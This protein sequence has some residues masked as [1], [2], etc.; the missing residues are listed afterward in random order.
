MPL[1]GRLPEV[2]MLPT[3]TL[4]ELFKM[5]G[6]DGIDYR[7]SV[8]TTGHNVAL[9]DLDAATVVEC[10]LSWISGVSFQFHEM[11]CPVRYE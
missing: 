4:A 6:Y 1:L 11:G 7:S 10:H 8:S 2:T 3:Q 9:F 5:H